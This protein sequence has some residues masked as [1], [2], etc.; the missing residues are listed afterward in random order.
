MAKKKIEELYG[1][2]VIPIAAA[3]LQPGFKPHELLAA[4]VYALQTCGQL[5]GMLRNKEAVHSL[6]DGAEM[7]IGYDGGSFTADLVVK[8][9]SVD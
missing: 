4:L 3:N 9:V 7:R 1:G 8:G 5:G 2:A 6:G